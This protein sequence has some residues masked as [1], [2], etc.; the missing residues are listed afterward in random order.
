AFGSKPVCVSSHSIREYP[1]PSFPCCSAWSKYSQSACVSASPKPSACNRANASSGRMA[2]LELEHRPVAL[3]RD[4]SQRAVG[5]H[6]DGMSD[7]LEER[8]IRVTVGVRRA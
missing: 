1:W 6:H 7:R 4:V 3:G 8:E 5:V 2:R